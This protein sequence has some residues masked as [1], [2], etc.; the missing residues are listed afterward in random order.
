VRQV[1]VRQVTVRQAMVRQVTVRQVTVRQVT[2]GRVAGR[3][4]AAG[5]LAVLLGACAAGGAAAPA[6]NVFTARRQVSL[7]RVSTDL[8]ALYRNHPG[9]QSFAVQDV[10]YT[11]QSR[12]A[13]LRECAAGPAAA[14]S[15]AAESGQVIA[16]APLIFF[17]YSYGRQASVPAAV[18]AAGE[19]YRYA[20]THITGPLSARASLN[21]LLHGWKVPVPGLTP[22]QA[23]HAAE[24]AVISAADESILAR[25]SVHLVITG[26]R[27]GSTGAAEQIVADIGAATGTESIRSGPAAATIRVTRRDAYFTGN[28]AGLTSLIGLTAAAAGKVR[29][30]W[31]DI[32][33]GTSEYQDLA[34]EDTIAS[35]PA[36]IL[37]ASG[38]AVHLRAATRSGRKVYVLD[39]TT[40]ASGSATK[41]SEELVLTATA[42][43][44]PISET[45]AA[46]GDS[47][48]VTLGHWGERFAVPVPRSPVPYSR[49][50]S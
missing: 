20:V 10:Q 34:A 23:A 25:K 3:L 27:T 16:C 36:T 8:S 32:T 45:T 11:A 40:T 12:N 13:I 50:T 42:G 29:S 19:L 49:V 37:P 22:A 5:T 7:Q 46:N 17:L 15:Q 38:N 39:W 44:L 33:G 18:S 47:Q 21:E 28:P 1:T 30:R 6:G 9:I 14:Q 43:D 4:V 31:V 48:T 35:L 2:A 41:V 24:A 26:R